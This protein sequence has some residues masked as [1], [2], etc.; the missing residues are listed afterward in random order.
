MH[1]KP[2]AKELCISIK[3]TSPMQSNTTQ[4]NTAH[5]AIFA[6]CTAS[7]KN[8][9][10]GHQQKTHNSTEATALFSP[11]RDEAAPQSHEVSAPTSKNRKARTNAARQTHPHRTRPNQTTPLFLSPSTHIPFTS[12]SPGRDSCA[13]PKN[14]AAQKKLL[15]GHA[16]T[17]RL[18]NLL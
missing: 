18:A 1:T 11:C 9:Q 12:P 4:H 6:P 14:T 16:L 2:H 5:H 8:R 17:A 13:P 15:G 3:Q 7:Q 10:A